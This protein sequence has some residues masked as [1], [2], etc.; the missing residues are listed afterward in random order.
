VRRGYTRFLPAGIRPPLTCRLA[1]Q[2]D[3]GVQEHEHPD[4][5]PCANE[6]R[7]EPAERLR[8]EDHFARPD[9]FENAI[10]VDRQP[11]SGVVAGKVDGDR[12]MLGLLE[13][14]HK[15]MPVPRHTARPWNENECR[16][17]F[18]S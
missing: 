13:Q 15:T 17:D 2:R 5:S 11:G 12:L 7:S 1:R 4:L 3:H 8:D 18:P 6:R 16:H 10:C 14:R 9:R